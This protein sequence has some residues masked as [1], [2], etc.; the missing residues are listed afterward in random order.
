MLDNI[1]LDSSVAVY[2]QIENEVQFAIVSGRL[3][4]G[5]QLPTSKAL[6]ERLGVNFNTVSKAYR[7]LEVMGIVFT[8]RGMGVY[9]NKGIEAKCRQRILKRLGERLHEVVAEAKA[10]GMTPTE[11]R[12]I[13]A[14]SYAS[15]AG[16][17]GSVP[18]SVAG[19][20]KKR[21]K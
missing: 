13:V 5:D 1:N 14:A 2:V 8:R 3:Q 4:A 17:Y 16:P 11:L 12:G 21:R 9:I 6:A 10:A 15:D 7:D 19:L 18:A 20:A